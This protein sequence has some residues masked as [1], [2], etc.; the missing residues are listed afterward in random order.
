ML[1]DQLL[2]YQSVLLGSQ[3]VKLLL[4][5][6]LLL[7]TLLLLLASLFWALHDEIITWS[8][9]VVL[10]S[11]VNIAASW[12]LSQM[13]DINTRSLVQSR[14][15]LRLIY[16][17]IIMISTLLM[18]FDRWVAGTGPIVILGSSLLQ[19]E[20]TLHSLTTDFSTLD[21]PGDFL[22]VGAAGSRARSHLAIKLFH[23]SYW[24]RGRVVLIERFLIWVVLG[25]APLHQFYKLVLFLMVTALIY[26]VRAIRNNERPVS[27]IF[28]L[29]AKLPSCM[30][31]LLLFYSLLL[32]IQTPW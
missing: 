10:V 28:C 31:E 29:N 24:C 11:D 14:Q 26:T 6:L 18:L 21:K 8:S 22:V 17:S 3:N 9:L 4:L 16:N 19:M 32:S 2:L 1:G 23:S 13:W 7:L 27:L 12:Y 15:F 25:G 5:L 20:T 30:H